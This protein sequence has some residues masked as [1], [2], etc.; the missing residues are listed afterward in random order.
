MGGVDTVCYSRGPFTKKSPRRWRD[1]SN[2]SAIVAA[3]SHFMSRLE[4]LYDSDLNLLALINVISAI[5]YIL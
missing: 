1:D 3:K 5:I 4:E 2:R